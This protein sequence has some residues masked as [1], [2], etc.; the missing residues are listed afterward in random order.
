MLVFSVAVDYLGNSLV[1][2]LRRG[3]DVG[4]A[5]GE[6]RGAVQPAG[7]PG[8]GHLLGSGKLNE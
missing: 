1:L 7:R 5:A 8:G 2:L 3:A 6:L 4:R